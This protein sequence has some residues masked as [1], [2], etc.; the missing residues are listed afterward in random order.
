MALEWQEDRL[1]VWT[2]FDDSLPG[3]DRRV[4]VL[5]PGQSPPDDGIPKYDMN[6]GLLAIAELTGG[7]LG[8]AS[9]SPIGDSATGLGAQYPTMGDFSL[10]ELIRALKEWLKSLL[11][12]PEIPW[13]LIAL[14]V[15]A[16]VVA[17]NR[18]GRR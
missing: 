18:R 4:T 9:G 5:L 6:G 13:A 7:R 15:A 16:V 14:G 11:E 2:L 3:S 8:S 12:L 17:S 1:G 10:D